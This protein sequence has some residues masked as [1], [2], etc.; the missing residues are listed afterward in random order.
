VKFIFATTESHKVPLTILSRCQR[1]NFKRITVAETMV[2][3]EDIAKKEKLKFE[4]NALFLIAKASE[5]ALRDAESL[6]DQLATFSKDKIQESDVLFMLGLASENIYFEVLSALRQQN[7]SR[8]FE[9]IAQ[10]YN[11]G[12]DLVYFAKGLLELFRHL[13]LYQ[14]TEKADTYSEWSESASKEFKKVKN[15]FSRGE[16]LL[17]LSILQNLQ[18]QLRRNMAPPKLLL[19]ATLLKLAHLDGLRALDE[20]SV[21]EPT[22]YTVSPTVSAPKPA[23]KIKDK[24]V[25]SVSLP[26]NPEPPVKKKLNTESDTITLTEA[27]TYWPRVIEYVK[28]QRMSTGIFLS[29]SEPVEI[30][31]GVIVLGLPSELQFHQETLQKD[32]NRKLVEDAFE[33]VSSKKVRIQFVITKREN[34]ENGESKAPAAAPESDTKLPEIIEE[35]MNIFQGA[36]VVRK[37]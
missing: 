30:D 33:I 10:L 5:G 34:S 4:P 13:L 32:N 16:L 20:E 17:S 24:A 14:C 9:I 25:E 7:V 19:E 22:A 1:F 15:D 28:T 29:E 26:L 31:G 37:D 35:A 6:L 2:K 27:E 18:A 8:V 11:E 21:S 12:I 3:L 23:M 36:R